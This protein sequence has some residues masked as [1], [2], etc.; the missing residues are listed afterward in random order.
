MITEHDLDEAI[1]ACEG[2]IKPNASTCMKLASFYTIRDHLSGR[3]QSPSETY[4]G[5]DNAGNRR[6]Y[7]VMNDESTSEF[8][9][10][11]SVVDINDAVVIIDELMDT[12]QVMSP[13]LY[14]GVIRKL[15]NII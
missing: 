3:T 4:S 11:I 8:M 7:N 12:I 14:S 15:R 1:A 6:P 9:R 2:E 5:A 13:R 10:L